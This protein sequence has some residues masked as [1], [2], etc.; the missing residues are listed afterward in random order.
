MAHESNI[1]AL[2]GNSSA[3]K[4][5]ILLTKESIGIQKELLIESK[6]TNEYL[7]TITDTEFEGHDIC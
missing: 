6:L 3:I 5:L 7:K 2:G 4:E 1:L